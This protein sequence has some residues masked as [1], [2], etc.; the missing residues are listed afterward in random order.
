MKADF[1][2]IHKFAMG[3][4]FIVM[5]INSGAVHEVSKTAWDF[6]QA[7]EEAGGDSKQARLELRK[8]YEAGELQLVQD[9]LQS[10]IDEGM[11][12][13]D[14]R[15]IQN[16]RAESASYVKALCLH[17]AHDCNMRCRYCFAG[18]GDFGGRRALMDLET[19][20]QALEFLFAA[21]G[22]RRHV[23]V[24]YFGGEPLL[25]FPVVKQL[26]QYGKTRSVQLGKVLKQTLT[27]NGLLLDQEVSDYLNSE[28]ISLVL[29]LDGRP[30]VNDAMR[31]L[32]GG[33]GSYEHIL[34]KLKKLVESRHGTNYYVRGTYTHANLDFSQDVLHMVEQGFRE[35]SVEPVVADSREYYAL[36]EED[37]PVLE[38]EYEKLAQAWLNYRENGKGFNFFHFNID[39][40]HG[41]CLPKRLSGCGAGHEYLAVSP[42]GNLY[43]CHQFV[44]KEEFKVGN[45]QDGI[46]EGSWGKKFKGAHV[47]NKEAC[48]VC[49]ARFY[50]SGGCHA[51]A[52]NF[53]RDITIPYK[54][55]CRLEKKRLECAVYLQVKSYEDRAED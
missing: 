46:T 44:G 17:A 32:K 31:P 37:L 30:A 53:N 25:N 41:P 28:G 6:L 51:N 47:L 15:E 42:E 50:C 14:D 10:L 45:V 7:W 54:L 26:I 21:S 43:P 22:P 8:S 24:D 48:R 35:V 3:G 23:E 18:T 38:K 40:D 5:D 4:C 29:S 39:L 49:W 11:L 33:A 34:P 2:L 19:G 12:F 27:T 20:I 16:Y 55:G 36:H 9:E 52:F 13:G 1:S